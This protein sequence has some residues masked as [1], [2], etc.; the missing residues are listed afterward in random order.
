MEHL[1]AK[2]TDIFSGFGKLKCSLKESECWICFHH[3]AR[4]LKWM[5]MLIHGCWMCKYE[6]LCLHINHINLKG[7]NMSSM[8]THSACFVDNF[9]NNQTDT[10]VISFKTMV[11]WITVKSPNKILCIF[12]KVWMYSPRWGLKWLKMF[13]YV[14]SKF[15]LNYIQAD[16]DHAY[17][18]LSRDYYILRLDLFSFE[19]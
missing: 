10:G 18:L 12:K 14:A 3:A 2:E 16:P 11:S 13:P 19:T 6:T 5:Q 15:K 8:N 1:A 7:D 17:Y 9:M 4:N